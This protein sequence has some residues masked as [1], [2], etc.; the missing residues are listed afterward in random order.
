MILSRGIPTLRALSKL[1]NNGVQLT[2][3]VR[4]NHQWSYR[5]GPSPSSKNIILC[6]D[7]VAGFAWWWVLWH[8]WTEPGHILA[9]LI[10]PIHH[11]GPMRS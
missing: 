7:L 5:V 1:K 4:N 10:I 2:Q 6:A 8:L 3:T 9:N 11:N